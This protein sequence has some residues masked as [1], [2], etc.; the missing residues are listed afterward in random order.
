MIRSD[1]SRYLIGILDKTIGPRAAVPL[2]LNK[3]ARFLGARDVLYRASLMSGF[4]DW[5]GPSPL[6]QVGISKTDGR[7]RATLAHEC[8]H[9]L[10]DPVLRPQGF[11]CAPE[12]SKLQHVRRAH[13][14]V[15]E[16]FSDI[17]NQLSRAD[18]EVLADLVGL[19]LMVPRSTLP[20]LT[21][22]ITS[23]SSL[24]EVAQ[25]LR[26]SLAL[27]T[28]RIAD[29]GACYSLLRLV[30]TATENW[31]CASASGIPL[32]LRGRITWRGS[33]KGS[34]SD[35]EATWVTTVVNFNGIPLEVTSN[36]LLRPSHALL[37]IKGLNSQPSQA[38][39]VAPDAILSTRQ[40]RST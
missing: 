3:I 27:L 6:V 4:T 40:C 10:L 7:R 22:R 23:L 33:P 2:N 38:Q 39:V 15:D 25:E 16:L 28:N 31:V 26:T 24:R 12:D 19:E 32:A 9:L 11:E 5:T 29:S 13:S 18:I 37:F 36:I 1:T 34:R 30:P 14:I 8:G 20:Q 21:S 35:T 17:A